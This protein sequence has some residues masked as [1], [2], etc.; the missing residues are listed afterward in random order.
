[1]VYIIERY[2]GWIIGIGICIGAF[3]IALPNLPWI[4]PLVEED[5]VV[6]VLNDDGSCTI[7]TKREN[8]VIVWD[9]KGKQVGDQVRVSFREGTTLGDIINP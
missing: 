5:G 9:C 3:L 6:I 8:I 2:K 7:E 1:M 4:R